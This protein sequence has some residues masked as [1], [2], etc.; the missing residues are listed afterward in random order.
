MAWMG[1]MVAEEEEREFKQTLD[2]ADYIASFINP[3][4]V[5][6]VRMARETTRRVSDDNFMK[7]I[8]RLSG[9]S[10]PGAHVK[11]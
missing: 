5:E 9:R 1:A 2:F 4:G 6:Q 11:Q 10:G 8:E 7:S 3:K